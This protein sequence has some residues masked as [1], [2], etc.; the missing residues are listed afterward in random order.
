MFMTARS[1]REFLRLIHFGTIVLL[2]SMMLVCL[3]AFG[4]FFDWITERVVTRL[5]PH[6]LLPT[7][8]FLSGLLSA[9]S[10]T[11]HLSGHG[12]VRAEGDRANGNQ[13]DPYLW[14][15]QRPQYR[16]HGDDHR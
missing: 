2:F 13:A 9:F 10:S 4:G 8:I 7:V 11:N 14:R 12:S 5:K 1:R 15:L 3:P 16:K 6:H